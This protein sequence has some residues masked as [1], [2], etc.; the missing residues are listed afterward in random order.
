MNEE[1]IE[2]FEDFGET[3][4][5]AP[6]A[7]EW[8]FEQYL[9]LY[10]SPPADRKQ[11]IN[12]YAVN[13]RHTTAAIRVLAEDMSGADSHYSFAIVT[14]AAL[15]H[16]FAIFTHEYTQLIETV[17]VLDRAAL[18][19]NGEANDD[20][21]QLLAF[22]PVVVDNQKSKSLL[23]V[24]TDSETAGKIGL[25]ASVLGTSRVQLSTACIMYSL[26][27][28]DLFSSTAKKAFDEKLKRFKAGLDVFQ[29][30]AIKLS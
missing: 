22:K 13:G 23:P 7:H 26:M 14:Q 11:L 12:W 24:A 16:G 15:V 29:S 8:T 10:Q 27:T 17:K 18:D 30:V 6:H 3:V 5:V 4:A 19:R 21:F 9:S 28:S 1:S 20:Y 25:I 2:Q